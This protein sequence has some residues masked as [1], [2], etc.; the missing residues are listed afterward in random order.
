[1]KL[2]DNCSRGLIQFS[3]FQITHDYETF[4]ILARLVVCR[5]KIADTLSL[6]PSGWSSALYD[7]WFVFWDCS[8]LASCGRLFGSETRLADF[9]RTPHVFLQVGL[10][11]PLQLNCEAPGSQSPFDVAEV[12][13]SMTR[14]AIWFWPIFHVSS[15]FRQ[16]ST[17]KGCFKRIQMGQTLLLSLT[18][19]TRRIFRTLSG[20]RLPISRWSKCPAFYTQEG[21]AWYAWRFIIILLILPTPTWAGQGSN[22][23][24]SGAKYIRSSAIFF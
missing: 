16:L 2:R 23:C 8:R 14:T 1:M 20:V 21:S 22:S 24:Y 3:E 7:H 6:L 12:R 13:Q 4:R 10:I 15:H 9:F 18:R 19:Y 11:P 5:S 17:F